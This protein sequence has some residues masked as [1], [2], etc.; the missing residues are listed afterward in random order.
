MIPFKSQSV[1]C[2]CGTKEQVLF[3]AAST[4]STYSLSFCS[5][6]TAFVCQEQR[7]KSWYN[8]GV[9]WSLHI[10]DSTVPAPC[11]RCLKCESASTSAVR[12]EMRPMLPI[13]RSIV[14]ISVLFIFFCVDEFR[15]VRSLAGSHLSEPY[16][17]LSL[18]CAN[19]SWPR[20]SPL[21]SCM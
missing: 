6:A 1:L 11:S 7:E 20:H 3:T 12:W 21:Q 8:H 18:H 5:S 2:P 14:Y 19:H 16:R 13:P 15:C 10:V 17:K 9:V 4:C